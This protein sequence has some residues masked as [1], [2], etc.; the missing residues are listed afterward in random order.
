MKFSEDLQKLIPFGYLFLVIMGILKESVLFYQLGIN[1][2]KYS[3]LMDILISPIATLTAHP[4][5]FLTTISIFVSCYYL[6]S[7]LYKY[8][9]NKWIR[10][11]FELKHTKLDLPEIE[12][13]KYYFAISIKSLAIGLLSVYLGYGSAEGFFI[14]KKIKNDDLKYDYT[15]NYNSGE[16]EQIF[17]V[18]ANSVY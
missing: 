12:I 18:S 9:H 8:D 1:I 14:S 10:K 15:L 3:T 5:T 17:L 13:K 11:I 7:F 2:L 4:I 6:P 16:A